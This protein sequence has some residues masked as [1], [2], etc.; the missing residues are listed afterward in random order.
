MSVIFPVH[1][2]EAPLNE[3]RPGYDPGTARVGAAGVRI[4]LRGEETS[5]HTMGELP[6]EYVG[7]DILSFMGRKLPILTIFVPGLSE[8]GL[9]PHYG[10]R[11]G[12]AFTL[13]RHL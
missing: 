1:T 6:C 3:Y 9:Y 5:V 7:G 13:L 11:V 12:I 8:L 4:V 2:A 10:I